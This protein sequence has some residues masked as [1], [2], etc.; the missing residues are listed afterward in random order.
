MRLAGSFLLVAA[1]TSAPDSQPSFQPPGDGTWAAISP[2][3]LMVLVPGTGSYGYLAQ[4]IQALP[5]ADPVVDVRSVPKVASD[6][7]VFEEAI[8][9]AERAGITGDELEGGALSFGIWGTGI[10]TVSGFEYISFEGFHIHVDVL[11]GENTCAAGGIYQNLGN[12]SVADANTDAT[13][14]NAAVVAWLA[15]HPGSAPRDVVFASH[16]WGGAVAEYLALER[17]TI[18]QTTGPLADSG[19]IATAP[20]TVASGV[21]EL[22]LGYSFEGPG[23]HDLSDQASAIYEIDRPDD[24][25]HILDPFGN[26]DGHYYNIL[27]GD[28]FEGYYDITTTA[29]SCAGV[30]GPC[31]D[32]PS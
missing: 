11:G 3:D 25:V 16:S 2:G 19:G 20:L 28:V 13:A 6:A 22:I 32:P 29:I 5:G 23:L 9:A 7:V 26:G 18:E 15:A 21:P 17:P 8:A 30:P 31:Q 12:Y 14:L 24:P 27:F 1:C 4:P 10:T